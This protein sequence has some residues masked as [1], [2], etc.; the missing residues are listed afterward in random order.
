MENNDNKNPAA[1]AV[2]IFG[3]MVVVLAIWGLM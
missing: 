1:Y 2:L 3:V